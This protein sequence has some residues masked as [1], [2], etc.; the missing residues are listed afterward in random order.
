LGA[1]NRRRTADRERLARAIEDELLKNP[2]APL[3]VAGIDNT[4]ELGFA[5]VEAAGNLATRDYTT[6]IIDLTE[7]GSSGLKKAVWAP[8][9]VNRPTVLRPRG[10]PPLARGADDLLAIGQWYDDYS[11]PQPQLGDATLVLADLDPA[12]GADH[13]KAWADRLIIVVTAGRTSAERIRTVG[14][15]ARAAGLTLLFAAL[16][17]T[18]T[19]DD[20]SGEVSLDRPESP[21][22][23]AYLDQ[24]PGAARYEA[25]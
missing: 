15:I 16:M 1:L 9:L 10:L 18:E 11:A 17:H 19:T 14:E 23:S 4:N 7:G 8:A 5:L 21:Q 13:L 6:T 3:V 20:S 24:P 25:R 2:S 12:I 22:S